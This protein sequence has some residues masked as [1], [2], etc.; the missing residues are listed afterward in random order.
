MIAIVYSGSRYSNWRLIG[1]NEVVEVRT[2]GI[3]PFFNDE[4]FINQ[5]LNKNSKLINNAEAIKK[6]YFFG[7]GASSKER[8]EIIKNGL[9]NF[10]KFSK[11]YVENDLDAAAKASCDEKPGIV[12]IIGSGS[13]AAFFDGKKI[14]KNNF[15]LGYAIADEGSATWMGKTLLKAYLSGNMPEDIKLAFDRKYD[16]DRRLMMDKIYKLPHPNLFLNSFTSFLIENRSS[17]F[18]INL[19]K[20]GFSL[21]MDTYLLPVYQSYG[22]KHPIYFVGTVAAFF[23]DFL[24]EVADEK[25][26][27][28]SSVIKEPIYNLLNYYA[29]KN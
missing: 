25:Q 21:F 12:C 29:N 20:S 5:L 4:K 6:I 28:I 27:Q 11:V 14:I 16:L 2:N 1:K 7:A 22:A 8:K 23:Q 10:F 3:N 26:I 19:V 24:R 13:N 17:P 18:I 15:G 9:S